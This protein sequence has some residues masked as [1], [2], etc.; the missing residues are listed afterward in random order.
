MATAGKNTPAEESRRRQETRHASRRKAILEAAALEFA[1]TGYE[2][3]TLDRIGARV[4]LTKASLYY[5]VDG[6]EQLLAELLQQVVEDIE[7]RAAELSAGDSSPL[8]RLRA[9][10]SAHMLVG[11]TRAAGKILTENLEV[12]TS[13]QTTAKL[14]Q[15]HEA[16]LGAIIQAGIDVGDFRPVA[17]V[18]TVKLLL[19][20]INAVPRWFDLQGP[21]QL[22]DLTGH[23]VDTFLSGIKGRAE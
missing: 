14:M 1:E 6:K 15:R 22:E 8:G 5:Y 13:R 12:L 4:G 20:A 11:G 19:G 9:F 18:P 7:S 23:V 16:S 2:R 17:V 10:V 3:A 21:L